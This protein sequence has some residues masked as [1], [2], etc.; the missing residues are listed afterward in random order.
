MV[1]SSIKHSQSYHK[2]MVKV[3]IMSVQCHFQ[4]Q[5]G[6]MVAVRNYLPFVMSMWVPPWVFSGIHVAH[7]FSFLCCAFCF[8]N[9]FILCLMPSV[10]D[11][12]GLSFSL[13]LLQFSLMFIY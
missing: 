2:L 9:V 8:V 1:E 12:S 10:A 13:L 6:Y 7:L 11:V 5:L 4:Q 3:G